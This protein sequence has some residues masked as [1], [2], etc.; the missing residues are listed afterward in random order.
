MF[1]NV[2]SKYQKLH[3]YM[4]V[5]MQ[6]QC[7]RIALI[8]IN[9]QSNHLVA[10]SIEMSHELQLGMLRPLIVVVAVEV[11]IVVHTKSYPITSVYYSSNLHVM[12]SSITSQNNHKKSSVHNFSTHK[13]CVEE[14]STIEIKQIEVSMQC[15]LQTTIVWSHPSSP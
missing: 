6:K 12:N 10:N 2:T 3:L 14:Y 8:S 1:A 15:K 9:V 4:L 7:Q 11:A 5:S 13:D